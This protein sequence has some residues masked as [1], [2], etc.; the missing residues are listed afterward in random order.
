MVIFLVP[1]YCFC[2]S[3]LVRNC[4]ITQKLAMNKKGMC[5]V[6]R[7]GRIHS[8]DQ[9]LLLPLHGRGKYQPVVDVVTLKTEMHQDDAFLMTHACDLQM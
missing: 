7:A 5:L 9:L 4:D 2:A 8:P 3:A 1:R 6:S